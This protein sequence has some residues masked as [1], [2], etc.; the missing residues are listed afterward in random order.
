MGIAYHTNVQ[1]HNISMYTLVQREANSLMDNL[2]MTKKQLS[3]S[4]QTYG[5]KQIKF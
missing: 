4:Q 5:M 3:V 1:F 2:E